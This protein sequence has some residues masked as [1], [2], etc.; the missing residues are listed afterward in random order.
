M[1]TK[2][3]RIELESQANYWQAQCAQLKSKLEKERQENLLNKAK[4]KD[5]Q[6]RLFGKKSEKGTT[7]KSEKG[8]STH[9][10][11][12]AIAASSRAAAGMAAPSDPIFR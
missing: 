3:E 2:Q 7:A 8:S 12:N 6:N 11:P 10:H 9:P 4:I 1:I 5:L